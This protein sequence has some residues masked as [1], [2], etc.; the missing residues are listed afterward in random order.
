MR[1]RRVTDR[2]DTAGLARSRADESV[3][4]CADLEISR[5]Q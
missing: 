5:Q 1:A 2:R 4:S 3:R